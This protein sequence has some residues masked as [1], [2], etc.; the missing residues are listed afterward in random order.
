MTQQTSLVVEDEAPLRKLVLSNLKASGY[1][2]LAAADGTE[3]LKLIDEQSFDLLL[4]D[5]NMPGPSRLQVLEAVRRS[6]E[7]RI[8]TLSGRARERDRVE[9]L[10][11]GADDYL[12]KPFGV[13]GS[14]WSARLLP[15]GWPGSALAGRR[16]QP[17]RQRPEH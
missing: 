7:M 16:Q 17:M 5:V 11:L 14:R 8:L 12:A 4:L 13:P 9:A 2:V 15:S 1:A 3:A 10:H 6:A